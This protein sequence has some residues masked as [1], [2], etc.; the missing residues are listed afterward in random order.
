[1]A[2]P[3]NTR[4]APILTEIRRLRA[5]GWSHRRIATKVGVCNKTVL[6]WLEAPT[7]N[8][9]Q[10]RESARAKRLW[11]LYRLTEADFD[12]LMAFQGG[13]CAV[14]GRPPGKKRLNIDHRHDTGE[15]F[16]LLSFTIN[17]GLAYF[18]DDPALL[19]AAANYLEKPPARVA[20]GRRVFGL[21]GRAKMGKKKPVYGP[22]QNT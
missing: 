7:I 19:R 16:G 13:R 1:M 8:T 18:N 17:K 5:A 14:S 9:P 6:R 21:L 3:Q 2:R 11:S 10:Q 20:L 4:K 22:L 12:A 15:I